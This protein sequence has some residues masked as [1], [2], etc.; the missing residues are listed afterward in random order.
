M[1]DS[2]DSR[3][4]ES[5]PFLIGQKDYDEIFKAR[6]RGLKGT[7]AHVIL[8]GAALLNIGYSIWLVSYHPQGVIG[9]PFWY[10]INAAVGIA[11]LVLS[12]YIGPMVRRRQYR[13]LRFE[14]VSHAFRADAH[15][16]KMQREGMTTE[17]SWSGL[18]GYTETP[19]HFFFWFNRQQGF[20]LPKRAL[21]EPAD[22]QQ[23]R[24]WLSQ[25]GIM[26]KGP[27]ARKP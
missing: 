2:A 11:L 12:Y 17:A 25:A 13:M 26:D 8:I 7:P 24:T 27:R 15:G 22:Q 16:L 20:I 10:W 6:S 21:G 9:A 1:A 18:V 3:V 23:L 5:G 19:E 4:V 14:G